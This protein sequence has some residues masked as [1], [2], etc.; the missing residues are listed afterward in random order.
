MYTNLV[1]HAREL[2]VDRDI[3]VCMCVCDKYVNYI[4]ICINKQK[5]NSPASKYL[6]ASLA[7]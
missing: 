1:Q 3:F 7:R 5:L 2:N 6:A 4:Y